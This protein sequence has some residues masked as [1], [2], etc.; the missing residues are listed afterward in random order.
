MFPHDSVY[1]DSFNEVILQ[2]AASG[3]NQKIKNDMAWDLQRSD[4]DALLQ[5]TKSKKFSFAD[6]E[7]RKLNLADTE[8]MFLLM[9][10]GYIIGTINQCK[11]S[12]KITISNRVVHHYIKLAVYWCRKLLVDVQGNY[13]HL[14][15]VNLIRLRQA[16]G[17]WCV[18]R[19]WLIRLRMQS[20]FRKISP[21]KFGTMLSEE[22]WKRH[23]TK[24]QQNLD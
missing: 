3:L 11:I 6:V 18:V 13:V 1:A 10:V 24:S 14:F 9:A 8:G 2:L 17:M 20:T 12:P 15:V 21:I 23:Q 22:Y 4:T 7:E 19:V 5:S 16:L